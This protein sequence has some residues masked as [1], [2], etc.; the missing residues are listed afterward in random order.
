MSHSYEY[1]V[2]QGKK[3]LHAVDVH[4]CTLAYY[5]TLVCEI[6]HGGKSNSKYTLGDYARDLGINRRTLSGWSLIYR[7][8][9]AKLEMDPSDVTQKEWEIARRVSN[10]LINEKRAIQEASGQQRKKGRGWNFNV[11]MPKERVRDLFNAE[12]LGR[13]AQSEIHGF[14]DTVIYIKNKLRRMDMSQVST[15]SIQSLKKNLDE[16]SSELTDYLMEH[17]GV[18][19]SSLQEGYIC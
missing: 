15:A 7:N 5:T 18:S 2:K 11:L 3:L 8:V 17:K 14:T 4:Q 19:L 13:S 16:A 6:S 12:A 9:I 1:Y 10:V